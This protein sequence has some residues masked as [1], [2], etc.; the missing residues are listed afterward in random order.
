MFEAL[1]GIP[2]V[3]LIS[4][5]GM[6]H[7]PVSQEKYRHL[8]ATDSLGNLDPIDT[9]TDDP[10][11]V[12]TFDPRKFDKDN[13]SFVDTTSVMQY[14]KQKDGLLIGGDTGLL[15][16]AAAVGGTGGGKPSTFAI[17]NKQADMRWGTKKGRRPWEIFDG[18][19]VFQCQEQGKW[20]LPLGQVRE[21]VKK[22]VEELARKTSS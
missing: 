16:L 4:L 8:E 15:N 5:E 13:G 21:E 22:R 12:V 18:V 19:E 1:R 17:L 6:G 7:R 2:G 11:E 3:M 14:I 20:E 10:S 9:T